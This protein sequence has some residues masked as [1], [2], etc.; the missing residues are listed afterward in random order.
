MPVHRH[1]AKVINYNVDKFINIYFKG[2]ATAIKLH[3]CFIYRPQ[4]TK[5][6]VIV[7][8]QFKFRN[9]NLRCYYIIQPTTPF[10]I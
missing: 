10:L 7:V 6:A 4:V 2:Y 1:N 5:L 8:T 3:E 9:K